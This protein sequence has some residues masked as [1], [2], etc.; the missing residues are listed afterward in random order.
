MQVLASSQVGVLPPR[1]APAEQESPSVHASPS[2]HAVEVNGVHVPGL[3]SHAWQSNG[4]LPPQAV[5]QQ[6]L[7]SQW[8]LP[9]IVSR[10]QVDP[11][12]RRGSHAPALQY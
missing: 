5:A 1:Q 4:S 12:G 9:H 6:T 2:S 10:L 3:T 8:P 7:S 11:S